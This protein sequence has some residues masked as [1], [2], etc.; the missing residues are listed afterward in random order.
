MDP[1]E[2]AH[3]R[4]KDIVWMSQNT[5]HLPSH[6]AVDEA[7]MGSVRDHEYNLYPHSK[8]VQ[9]LPEAILNDLHAPSGY[10]A[11]V[12]NGGIEALYI[13]TRTLLKPGDT[14]VATDPSFLPI[15][16][17]IRMCGAIPKELNIYRPPWKLTP[18]W[19]N[20]SID[21]ST[22]MLLLIDPINPLGTTYT[23]DEVRALC[24]IAEDRQLTVIDDLTYRDFNPNHVPAY[25]FLPDSTVVAYS[26]SKSCGMAGMRLGALVAPEKLMDKL[27]VYNT[28]V[29]SAN[30][31][32]Q[33]AALAA[34][35]TKPQW[36]DGMRKTVQRNQEIIKSAVDKVNGTFI[37]VYPSCA[38]ML[39]IDVGNTGVDPDKVQE[40]MLYEHQ[41]FVR[42]GKYVSKAYGARF[43][44]VSFTVPEEGA[45]KFAKAFVQVMTEL[46]R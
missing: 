15:H 13:M 28:N 29:L 32:A 17:E 43:V 31:L 8:G 26:F 1:F 46:T 34:L 36:L 22:R 45:Q 14:V 10:H 44:R 37:P 7:I 38:N 30:V 35:K 11:L 21:G 24:E 18:E 2:Y 6:P 40:K 4:A 41:V 5:N 39:V 12:T 3:Q 23:K 20:E 27:K 19:V 42:S 33:R 16:D 25:Q 9:G